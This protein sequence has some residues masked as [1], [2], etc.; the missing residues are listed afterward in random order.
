M[1]L[2]MARRRQSILTTLK[3][4]IPRGE[5][6]LIAL[7]GGKDSSALLHGLLKVRRLLDLHLE[8]C[9]VD[10]GL[11]KESGDD[12]AAVATMCEKLGVVCHPVRLGKR[13]PQSN[14]EAWARAERYRALKEVMEREN[15]TLLVTAHNANDVAETLLMRLFA[16][17]ELTTIEESDR[18]RRCVRPLL[19]VSREQIEEFVRENRVPFVE[20]PS[21]ADTAMVRNRV[22]K[23]VLPLLEREFDPSMVW[24]LSERAQSIAADCEALQYVAE[25]AAD[26]VGSVAFRDRGWL[27]RCRTELQALP[28][29]I[30]WRVAQVLFTPILGHTVGEPRARALVALLEGTQQS[31]D[32][33]GGTVL[34]TSQGGGGINLRS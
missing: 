5:R 9:H 34:E 17:K 1:V 15:L 27:E 31:L 32:L 16:N 8:A 6:V 11:R 18:R 3:Q 33:G 4:R 10:H 26:R 14:M 22:R 28:Y 19:G 24:I 25:G 21:N 20:D 23:K 12:A 30:K 2:G 13:P 7:S 29:A